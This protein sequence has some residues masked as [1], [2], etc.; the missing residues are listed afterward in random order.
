VKK[1]DIEEI[2]VL[3]CFVLLILLY[4]SMNVGIWRRYGSVCLFLFVKNVDVG[5]EGVCWPHFNKVD[6]F[7]DGKDIL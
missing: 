5:V 3:C 6:Y 4:L 2:I 1:S 7:L